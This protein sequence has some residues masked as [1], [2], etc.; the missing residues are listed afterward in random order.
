MPCHASDMEQSRQP[1][2]LLVD[3][4]EPEEL[5]RIMDFSLP[6]NGVGP[7]GKSQLK[8]CTAYLVTNC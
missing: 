3:Y 6:D 1:D 8:S 4:K 2:G 5:E 7:E